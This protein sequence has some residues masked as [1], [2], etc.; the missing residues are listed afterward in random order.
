MKGKSKISVLYVIPILKIGGAEVVFDSLKILENQDFSIIKLDLNIS[1]NSFFTY[2]KAFC[3]IFHV[4]KNNEI[5]FVISSLWKSHLILF[6]T[7]F[8]FKFKLVPFIHSSKFFNYFDSFFSKW[9]LKRSFAVIVDSKSVS[10]SIT[11]YILHDRVFVVSM[12]TSKPSVRKFYKGFNCNLC[13]V[14]LGRVS[15]SKRLD[16]SLNFLEEL[17]IKLPHHIIS[18]D[19]FG[20][21]EDKYISNFFNNHL[22]RSN[23]RVTF[24]G[25][26]ENKFVYNKLIE[27]DFYLQ[28]SD[29]EGMSMSVMDAMSV[30]LIP[31][32]TNVGE[33]G[34]YAIDNFNSL[35]IKKDDQ[36]DLIVSKLVGLLAERE[37]IIRISDNAFTTFESCYLFNDDI[38]LILNKI[39]KCVE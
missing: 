37:N 32:V 36:V 26:I 30:G 34:N 39:R 3:K 2:F 14:F 11:N 20:P 7:R 1:N 18:L 12:R 35:L 33:I 13:F 19:I 31:I 28:L 16:K 24:H 38:F 6:F 27:Y 25:S 5:D 22:F 4:L 17:H 15:A 10:K 8:F 29:I 9:I 21:L 23:V